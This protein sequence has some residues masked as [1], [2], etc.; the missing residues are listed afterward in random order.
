[1]SFSAGS[2]DDEDIKIL[3]VAAARQKETTYVIFV[4]FGYY[5]LVGSFLRLQNCWPLTP[6]ASTYYFWANRPPR[7]RQSVINKSNGWLV[8]FFSFGT[9]RVFV[10]VRLRCDYYGNLLLKRRLLDE[11]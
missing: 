9:R 4:G 6:F 8:F 1:M 11:G 10:F 2:H 5:F 7:S 3:E